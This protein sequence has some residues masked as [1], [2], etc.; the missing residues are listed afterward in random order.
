MIKAGTETTKLDPKSHTW[1]ASCGA[2]TY[3]G[4]SVTDNRSDSVSWKAEHN[5]GLGNVNETGKLGYY[6]ITMG[7]AM[8]DNVATNVYSTSNGTISS[9]TA[10][11]RKK[12]SNDPAYQHGWAKGTTA[13][14]MGEVFTADLVVEPTLAGSATM[15]GPLAEAVDLDGSATLTFAFGL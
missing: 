1:T 10:G 7:N 8:V 15:N 6:Q 5:F 11:I 4:F 12:L 14:A 2:K 13:Q 3:L 9:N